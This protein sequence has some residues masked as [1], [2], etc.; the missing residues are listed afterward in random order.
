MYIYMSFLKYLCLS[1]L[2]DLVMG[3]YNVLSQSW[4]SMFLYNTLGQSWKSMQTFRDIGNFTLLVIVL[5]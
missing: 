2:N 1:Q 5:S 3:V 4:K